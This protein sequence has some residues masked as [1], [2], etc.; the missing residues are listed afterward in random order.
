MSE[1]NW[2]ELDK[3]VIWHPFTRMAGWLDSE[4]LIIDAAEGHYL[5]DTQGKRYL[6]GVSSLW[7]NLFGHGRAEIDEAIRQQL[8]RVA[9]STLLG[10]GCTPAVALAARLVERTYDPLTRVFYSDNG[11]TA[12]EVA[13]K[14]AYQYW[15]ILGRKSKTRFLALE[16][17]YHGDTLGSVSVG[18]IDL[19][20]R[21]FH[22]LLFNV[23]RIPTPYWYRHGNGDDPEGCR[24]LCLKALKT[25]LEQSHQE[26]AALI[27]EP[28]VQGAAGIIVHPEGYLREVVRLCREYDVLVIFDEVAVGFGRTG[29][30][31]AGE[32]E[33]VTPDL[34]ALAKGISGGYLPLAATLATDTIFA[35]FRDCPNELGTFFHGHSYTG[36]GLACAAGLASLDLFDSTNILPRLPQ[37]AALLASLL[38]EHVAPLEHCGQIRQKGLMVGI[39]LVEDRA[40]RQPYAA[41]NLVGVRVC[42]RV[43]DL[44]VMLRPLGPVLVLIPPLTLD[45]EELTLLVEATA[46]GI[47]EV[48][49]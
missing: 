48:T 38:A 46:Q 8:D 31:F 23:A 30:L 49:Q 26:L 10:L 11:S 9:H 36:N 24:D 37:R 35:A 29:T 19:F 25:T 21:I 34:L 6:D 33:G 39:E 28:L 47:R 2:S 14:M 12:V 13:L 27:I 5:I 22:P 32:Q 17:A 41:D 43:R 15:Q 42:Q 18:G 4:P 45:D 40:S 20:H 16:D 3:Q 1:T 44:G 7:V